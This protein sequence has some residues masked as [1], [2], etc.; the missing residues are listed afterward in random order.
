MIDLANQDFEATAEQY[1]LLARKSINQTDL[2]RYVKKMFQ[3][4]GDHEGSSRLKNI[5]E[6][7]ADRVGRRRAFLWLISRCR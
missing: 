6:E 1:R 3:V 4:K 5:M 2:R 7:T